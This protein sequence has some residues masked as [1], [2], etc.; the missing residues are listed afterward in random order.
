VSTTALTRRASIFR[1][2]VSSAK[3]LA[4]VRCCSCSLDSIQYTVLAD[5]LTAPNCCLRRDLHAPQQTTAPCASIQIQAEEVQEQL[6]SVYLALAATG[7]EK[8]S[9]FGKTD[10]YLKI[11]RPAESGGYGAL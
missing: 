10:P 11:S 6:Y 4:T 2:R 1:R 5:I 8:T 9:H 7:L 3:R